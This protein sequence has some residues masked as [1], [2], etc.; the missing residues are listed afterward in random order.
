[1]HRQ[2]PGPLQWVWYALGGG[3][4]RE[5]SPWVLADTTRRT[6]IVRHLTRSVV[7]MLPV[8]AICLL[9]VPV[10][11]AYRLSAAAGGLLLGLM[12]SIAFMTETI[13]HRVAKAGYPA[14]T[15]ARIRA[16]RTERERV[17][18]RAPYRQD[19]AGSFD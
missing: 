7:Q 2:R 5:L 10:P 11:L 17:E 6:W 8:V 4:P 18:R 12:F 14:G 15:A 1:M 16:E 9:A 3:L 19:G 13:E